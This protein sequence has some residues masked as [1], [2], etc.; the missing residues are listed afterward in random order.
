M[1]GSAKAHVTRAHQHDPIRQAELLQ[2]G[3]S[4]RG[5]FFPVVVPVVGMHNL[6]HLD[7]VELVLADHI[8]HTKEMVRV[9][10]KNEGETLKMIHKGEN[11][12]VIFQVVLMYSPKAPPTSN[13]A[14]WALAPS[15]AF[16]P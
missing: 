7:P 2:H 12:P 13:P 5:H 1:L 4:V 6:H 10:D 16:T 15:F 9:M 8:A 3:F 14:F 11:F